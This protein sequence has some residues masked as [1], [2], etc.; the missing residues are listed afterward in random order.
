MKK[1]ILTFLFL[2]MGL[3]LYAQ[4]QGLLLDQSDREPI[5]RA[6]IFSRDTVQTNDQGV[7]YYHPGR[8]ILIQSMG[9]QDLQILALDTPLVILLAPGPILLNAITVN[10]FGI[11]QRNQIYPG[12]I[13]QLSSKEISTS[14]PT[15]MTALFN[16]VPGEFLCNRE[17]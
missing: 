4:R 15:L 7:F 14:D 17:P 9:Y 3:Q 13:T 5:K 1:S 12:T 6:Y 11:P 8:E 2:F 10:D 16:Q